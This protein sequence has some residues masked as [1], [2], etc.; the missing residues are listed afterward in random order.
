MLRYAD[1]DVV[2]QEVPDEVSLAI[3]IAGCPNGCPGCHSPHLLDDAGPMLDAA[4]LHRLVECCGSGIT[5]VCF[6]G[7]DAAPEQ[8][9]A[10]ALGLR[11][12]HPHLRVAWYSGRQLLP[13]GFDTSAFDYIK[14]GPY[15]EA[16][17]PLSSPT[18]NQRML[19]RRPD[20]SWDDITSR[21]QRRG[22]LG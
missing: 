16:Q 3:S 19:R 18:T 8:V 10:L 14:L 2:F 1:T 21:F 11:E 7:G 13:Q 20:G 4:E 17:G 5:C 15:V 9:R 12:L 6:M 22:P